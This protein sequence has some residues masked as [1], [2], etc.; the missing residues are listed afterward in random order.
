M[1]RDAFGTLSRG[2]QVLADATRRQSAN[3]F[4]LDDDPEGWESCRDKLI[5]TDEKRGLSDLAVQ[6]VIRTMLEKR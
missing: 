6:V 3:W 2:R 4:A 1:D 5:L